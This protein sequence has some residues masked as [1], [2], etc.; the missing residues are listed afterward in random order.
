VSIANRIDREPVHGRRDRRASD[1]VP[2]SPH[3]TALQEKTDRVYSEMV[4]YFTRLEKRLT[5]PR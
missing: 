1:A 5:T 3:P 4:E 2:S